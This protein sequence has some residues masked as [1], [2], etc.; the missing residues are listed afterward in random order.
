VVALQASVELGGW[1]ITASRL[2]EPPHRFVVATL[3]AVNLC[4][5]QSV[6]L[7]F[8]LTDYFDRSSLS[9]LIFRNLRDALAGPVAITAIVTKIGNRDSALR[10]D[11][12]QL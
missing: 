10:L 12:L 1:L 2:Q 9:Q 6:K 11:L 4:G 7:V 5:R 8:L 3:R